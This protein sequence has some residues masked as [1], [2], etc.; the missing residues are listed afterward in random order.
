MSHF[1][2]CFA[3]SCSQQFFRSDYYCDFYVATLSQLTLLL[4]VGFPGN[5]DIC[6]VHLLLS[7]S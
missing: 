2:V 7:A 4:L 6:F 1:Y 3:Q 5:G